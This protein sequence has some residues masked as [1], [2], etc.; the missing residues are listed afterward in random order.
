MVSWFS[1]KCRY[2]T[3]TTRRIWY[4][5]IFST[6]VSGWGVSWFFCVIPHETLRH[7]LPLP[8]YARIKSWFCSFIIMVIICWSLGGRGRQCNWVCT[9]HTFSYYTLVTVA[10]RALV[11]K[12]LLGLVSL[13]VL[14]YHDCRWWCICGQQGHDRTGKSVEKKEE[15]GSQAISAKSV[16]RLDVDDDN[17]WYRTFCWWDDYY[18]NWH[19][20]HVVLAS[21]VQQTQNQWVL[22]KQKTRWD[23]PIT[24]GE[25]KGPISQVGSLCCWASVPRTWPLVLWQNAFSLMSR[26]RAWQC[27]LDHP[28][29][30]LWHNLVLHWKR[31]LQQRLSLLLKQGSWQDLDVRR[32]RLNLP[33]LQCQLPRKLHQVRNKARAPCPLLLLMMGHITVRLMSGSMNAIEVT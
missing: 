15:G 8:I 18:Q 27:F 31:Q 12:R 33:L 6:V 26:L 32:R 28:K 1:A 30:G 20:Q 14:V 4:H 13:L 24:L 5:A 21:L 22:Q 2:S 9:P 23:N 16:V 10:F 7:K 19:K 25:E 17:R 29:Q 11:K 3:A